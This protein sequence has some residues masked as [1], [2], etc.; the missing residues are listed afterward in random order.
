L[1][2]IWPIP[3]P[4]AAANAADLL[5]WQGIK[6]LEGV[7]TEFGLQRGRLEVVPGLAQ[8]DGTLRFETGVEPYTDKAGRQR[9]RGECV[10]GPL[11]D[12]FL[13]VSWRIRGAPSWIGRRK[14]QLKT[15]TPDVL[16]TLSEPVT[17]T[18]EVDALGHRPAGYVQEWTVV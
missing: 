1:R 6:D 16:S 15:L 2:V 9:F 14:V 5:G 3:D 8:P 17:L 11:D 7:S 12:P 18:T 4:G 10:Q 13:Y